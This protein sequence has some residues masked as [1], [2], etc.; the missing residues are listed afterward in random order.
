MTHTINFFFQNIFRFKIKE[1]CVSRAQL[2]VVK[3]FFGFPLFAGNMLEFSRA[4][5]HDSV[6]DLPFL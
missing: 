4:V 6:G 5:R 3:Y 1:T 2:L